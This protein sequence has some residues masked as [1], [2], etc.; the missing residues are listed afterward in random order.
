MSA[1]HISTLLVDAA[2]DAVKKWTFQPETVGGRGV[3]S[4]ALVPV[5]FMM[6]QTAECHWKERPDKKPV[7]S[8][9]AIALSSVVGIDTG[10]AA[11]LP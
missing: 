3:A 4:E 1:D 6:S 10:D 11:H 9:E 7:R 2:I 5:C 8:G